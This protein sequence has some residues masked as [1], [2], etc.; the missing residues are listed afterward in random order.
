[1]RE[2]MLTLR[3]SHFN[4]HLMLHGRGTRKDRKCYSTMGKAEGFM[5]GFLDGEESSIRIRAKREVT[6]THTERSMIH[7]MRSRAPYS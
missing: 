6:V 2:I 7:S 3:V 5:L 1:M 4:Q